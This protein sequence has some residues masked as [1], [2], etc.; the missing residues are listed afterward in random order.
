MNQVFFW[1]E[2]VLLILALGG[3]YGLG[4]YL[5]Y[6]QG[7]AKARETQ[8]ETVA[9]VGQEISRILAQVREGERKEKQSAKPEQEK[10]SI[11]E[12]M[13]EGSRKFTVTGRGS[14]ILGEWKSPEMPAICSQCGE[15]L[16]YF[17]G[18]CVKKSKPE[19]EKP[20]NS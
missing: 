2:I 19:Q 10:P 20:C 4:I 18:L 13:L 7:F 8:G 1:T 12:G 15:D 16:R 3:L 9:L 11:N 14:H 5:G 6:R 17:I